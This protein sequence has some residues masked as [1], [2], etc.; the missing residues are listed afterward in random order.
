[1]EVPPP[2][3]TSA[4]K[5]LP[6]PVLR[7]PP[8]TARS[9]PALDWESIIGVK[10]FAWVGGLALFLGVVFFVKYAFENNWITPTM[11]V[12]AGAA[13]GLALLIVSALPALRRFRVPAQSLG[14]SG[15]LILYADTYAAQALY[16][17]I[18][19]VTATALMWMITGLALALAL[20]LNTTSTAWL[21]VVG[22]FLTP[23]ILRT[24]HENPMALFIYVAVL[25]CAVAAI[26]TL[27][28]WCYFLFAAAV[29]T[30]LLNLAWAGDFFGS[31]NQH[32]AQIFLLLFQALF[33]GFAIWQLTR[34]NPGGWAWSAG[35]LVGLL[36]LLSIAIPLTDFRHCDPHSFELM[37]VADAGLVALVLIYRTAPKLERWLVVV[38]A[39][40]LALTWMS[41]MGW[42]QSVFARGAGAADL[43]RTAQGLSFVAV[44]EI[45][46]LLLFTSVP[47]FAGTQRKWPWMVARAAPILQFFAVYFLLRWNWPPHWKWLLPVFFALPPAVGVFYLVRKENVA[48]PPRATRAWPHRARRSS[49][50]AAWFCRF[51]STASG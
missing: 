45:G 7:P 43:S 23:I 10:L 9:S 25:D 31:A 42:Y 17:L 50:S 44:W 47:Y 18:P 27:K 24:G 36:A 51:N 30:I 28:R 26:A 40:A 14:A 49:P 46:I 39:G 21:A 15:L 8:F 35:V 22:G 29:G 37:L 33:L 34:A 20:W 13:T 5:P 32:D 3:P 19:L 48:P 2:L 4:A 16:H 1:M 12:T 6:P 41:E 38:T 11:R